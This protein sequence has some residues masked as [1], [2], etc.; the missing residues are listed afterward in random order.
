M[1]SIQHVLWRG[2]MALSLLTLGIGG[3]YGFQEVPV[4][5][6]TTAPACDIDAMVARKLD[7]A[8]DY[9]LASNIAMRVSN[10]RG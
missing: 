8:N 4:Q 3:G 2:A 9:V 5:A 1:R 6:D 10:K 7:I